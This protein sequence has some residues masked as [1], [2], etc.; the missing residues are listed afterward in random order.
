MSNEP[1]TYCGIP[2]QMD[3][4]IGDAE[5]KSYLIS[6]QAAANIERFRLK[7]GRMP[8]GVVETMAAML[9]GDQAEP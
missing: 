4:T 8:H 5:P 1:F 3:S 9:H 2:I 6:D 7:Y